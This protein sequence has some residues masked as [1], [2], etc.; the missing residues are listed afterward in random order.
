[1]FWV[2]EGIRIVFSFNVEGEGFIWYCNRSKM[3][4]F[5]KTMRAGMR[6][7]SLIQLIMRWYSSKGKFSPEKF[8]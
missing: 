7:L 1:M 2:L 5:S 3:R 8:C 6:K 4:E